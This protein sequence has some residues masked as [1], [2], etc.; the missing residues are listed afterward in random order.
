M[1]RFLLALAAI[2]AIAAGAATT[3]PVQAHETYWGAAHWRLYEW[4][5]HSWRRDRD[6]HVAFE[7][8][9]LPR[10]IFGLFHHH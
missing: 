1:R 6:R 4:R 8:H 7:H 5:D 9:V 2:G 3:T 10:I